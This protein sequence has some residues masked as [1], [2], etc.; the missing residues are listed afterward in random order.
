MTV[1][2]TFEELNPD[3]C[4]ATLQARYAAF[5]RYIVRNDDDGTVP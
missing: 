3:E 2:T 1:K 5:V 4:E